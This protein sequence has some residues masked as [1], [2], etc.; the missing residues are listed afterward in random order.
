MLGI[1]VDYL[2]LSV[3]HVSFLLFCMV[4]EIYYIYVFFVCSAYCVSCLSGL[5]V[6]CMSSLSGLPFYTSH[7][8][9]IASVLCTCISMYM[10]VSI[11]EQMR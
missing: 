6:I 4:D 9:D 3:L 2:Y 10:S 8:S 1:L 11:M 5:S 7:T